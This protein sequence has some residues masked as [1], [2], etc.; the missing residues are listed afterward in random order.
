MSDKQKAD[1]QKADQIE[2]FQKFAQGGHVEADKQVDAVVNREVAVS[3]DEDAKRKLQ[4]LDDEMAAAL[5]GDPNVADTRTN[6]PKKQSLSPKKKEGM[7]LVRRSPDGRRGVW[8]GTYDPTD[9]S[10][11]EEKKESKGIEKS[12]LD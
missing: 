7:A 4:E 12:L 3:M 9:K 8:K 11:D 1:K 6:S 10:D 2:A 5:F